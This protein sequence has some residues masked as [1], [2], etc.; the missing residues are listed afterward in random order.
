MDLWK[1]RHP[2]DIPII[3]Q[4]TYES[5]TEHAM[6]SA[7]IRIHNHRDS[8]DEV[9]SARYWNLAT[10]WSAHPIGHPLPG[11]YCNSFAIEPF[12]DQPT[13]SLNASMIDSIT[14][15]MKIRNPPSESRVV[16][17]DFNVNPYINRKRIMT[18]K[19]PVIGNLTGNT[20]EY[21]VNPLTSIS[22]T[23]DTLVET[24]TVD[25]NAT[26]LL[27]TETNLIVTFLNDDELNTLA[28]YVPQSNL[29]ISV[30]FGNYTYDVVAQ[31]PSVSTP[32]SITWLAMM[33]D[34]LLSNFEYFSESRFDYPQLIEKGSILE[35]KDPVEIYNDACIRRADCMDTTETKKTAAPQWTYSVTALFHRWNVIRLENGMV[36]KVFAN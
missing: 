3:D 22:D 5:Y 34:V 8:I 13:G 7:V 1:Y 19:V 4:N 30:P 24:F 29:T 6:E 11:C 14:I 36:H 18:I 26:T 2:N 27:Q 17:T 33:D 21:P 28:D 10:S 9:K 23:N 16:N 12:L 31:E 32:N 25:T 35:N 20:T 15:Q